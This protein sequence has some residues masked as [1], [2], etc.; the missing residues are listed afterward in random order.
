MELR[1]DRRVAGVILSSS[2]VLQSLTVTGTNTTTGQDSSQDRV[3]RIKWYIA[4]VIGVGLLLFIY[5][6]Y[7]LCYRQT[8]SKRKLHE[9]INE[10]RAEELM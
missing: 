6:V 10:A 4:L 3:L 9:L 7:R 5:L 2:D 8:M 1:I